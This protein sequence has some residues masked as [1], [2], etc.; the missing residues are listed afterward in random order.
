M[1]SGIS[2]NAAFSGGCD[3]TKLLS[4]DSTTKKCV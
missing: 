1:S 3:T 4:C 2:C